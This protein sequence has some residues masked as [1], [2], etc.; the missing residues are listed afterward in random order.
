M[1]HLIE[2]LPEQL[3]EAAEIT[4]SVSLRAARDIGAVVVAGLGG[5]AIGG[6]V[7]RAAVSGQLHVPMAINRD[8]RLPE[9]VSSSTVVFACSYSGDTEE[10]LAAYQEARRAGA[11]I[12]GI[13]SGGRLAE[14]VRADAYPLV[15]MPAGRPPRSAFGYSALILLGCLTKLGLVPDARQSIQETISLLAAL[16]ARYGTGVPER[17]NPAKVM[18][19]SLH[20]KLVA[21]YASSGLLDAAATRWRGQIEENAK[22]L[23]F[24]HLLPEMNHNELVGWDRPAE[25][26]RRIGVV[27]LRD[28]G[29][30]PQVRRRF[31]L[32]RDLL[33]QKAGVVHEVWTEGD[34]ALARIFS[35]IYFGDF[36]SLY[37]AYLN[38]VDPTPVTVIEMLR[39]ELSR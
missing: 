2:S 3:R 17:E 4:Q 26:L 19:R 24:H 35:M 8:Y 39:R 37:L 10:T 31:D 15:L 29:D 6:D 28:T 13:T 9:F 38:E 25:L 21:V 33:R 11:Q 5:S 34:S 16:S 30:H 20:A 18:A 14:L 23:A 1:K 7:V 32:T 12:V 36:V 27:F 22:N